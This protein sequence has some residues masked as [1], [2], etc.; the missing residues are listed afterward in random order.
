MLGFSSI[1]EI[2]ISV[3]N[4]LI[5]AS[6]SHYTNL[7]ASSTILR[8]NSVDANLKA[9]FQRDHTT[10]LTKW[11]S[12]T[13]VNFTDVCLRLSGTKTHTVDYF[14]KLSV[15]ADNATNVL[16]K[17]TS[18]RNHVA[19]THLRLS[20]TKIH[21]ADYFV[22]LSAITDNATNVLLKST[23]IRNHAADILLL[24]VGT[25]FQFTSGSIQSLNSV[26]SAASAVFWRV[27]E[28]P[29]TNTY[30]KV[31]TPL[32]GAFF[33]T[34]PVI[35]KDTLKLNR[36]V[37]RD[38]GWGNRQISY[39]A[40]GDTSDQVDVVQRLPYNFIGNP[41]MKQDVVKSGEVPTARTKINKMT[42]PSLE[43]NQ[44]FVQGKPKR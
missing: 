13:K 29:G 44:T 41:I 6:R 33:Y 26:S 9:S 31:R 21:T 7:L 11:A 40:I 22:R 42:F 15:M 20:G 14:I 38:S 25:K 24:A 30:Q 16:L 1:S 43:K 17:S 18:I 19:D 34:P 4:A 2:P 12:L 36:D 5:T 32:S 35:V 39:V 8:Q 23:N 10:G 37:L 27:I 3:A 28:G